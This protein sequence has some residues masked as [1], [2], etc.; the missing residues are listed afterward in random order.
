MT[1]GAEMNDVAARLRLVRWSRAHSPADLAALGPAEGCLVGWPKGRGRPDIPDQFRILPLDPE[2]PPHAQWQA[3][4]AASP[5]VRVVLLEQG[6][7]LV[8]GGSSDTDTAA[9]SHIR[10]VRPDAAWHEVR[11]LDLA[12]GSPTFE[13]APPG[14]VRPFCP[15]ATPSWAARIEATDSDAPPPTSPETPLDAY[16]VGR[17]LAVS[18][19]PHAAFVHLAN[20]VRGLAS[21]TLPWAER[22]L[23]DAASVLLECVCATRVGLEP[24]LELVMPLLDRFRDAPELWFGVAQVLLAADLRDDAAACLDTVEHQLDLAPDEWRHPNRLRKQPHWVHLCRAALERARGDSAAAERAA[25]RAIRTAPPGALLEPEMLLAAWNAADAGLDRRD[26]GLV[27]AR[28]SQARSVAVPEVVERLR[29]MHD[30]QHPDTLWAS[31]LL[32][33]ADPGLRDAPLLGGFRPTLLSPQPSPLRPPPARPDRRLRIL[34]G[35]ENIAGYVEHLALGLRDLGHAVETV[36]TTDNRFYGAFRPDRST[37][38]VVGGSRALVAP[39]G[40]VRLHLTPEAHAYL[41]S[42]DVFIV[43]AAQSFAPGNVDLPM[44]AEAGVRIVSWLPGS[45]SRHWSAAGPMWRAAGSTLP[46]AV[47]DR[48]LRNT[49]T[50]RFDLVSRGPYHDTLS[51]KLHNVRMA[52]RWSTSVFGVPECMGHAVRPYFSIPAPLDLSRFRYEVPGREVP[53][54]VHAPSHRGFKRTADLLEALYRLRAQGVR[55]ELRLL[56]SLPHAVVVEELAAA[57]VVLDQMSLYPAILAHEGMASGCAVL[58]GNTEF[59]LPV[60]FGKPVVHITPDTVH[61]ELQRV[62]T[63]RD[64]RLD[65]AARGRTYVE[66]YCDAAKVAARLLAAL[67]P[68]ARPD[69]YPRYFF[70]AATRPDGELVPPVV[71]TLTAEVLRRHGAPEGVDWADLVGRGLVPSDLPADA[72]PRW[73]AAR[74]TLGPWVEARADLWPPATEPGGPA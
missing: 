51:N 65:L 26:L 45:E 27:L 20:A 13:P 18:G 3:L 39:D 53:V 74:R 17:A 59:A 66:T 35:T 36:L 67:E 29:A 42:F 6:E 12:V 7:R 24:T 1:D 32:A 47:D 52:E 8:L 25:L 56:E 28:L 58:T 4:T 57:D 21:A 2:T 31:T 10:I 14:E 71:Q 44:L 49:S 30:R 11:L 15:D 34:I 43:V 55:F 46:D 41:T 61:R 16:F 64:L 38:E 23:V 40:D 63:D 69:L 54:V 19:D 68:D 72:V 60:P 73:T 48:G 50:G 70:D 33:A 9:A 22:T 37:P 62:L 5:P